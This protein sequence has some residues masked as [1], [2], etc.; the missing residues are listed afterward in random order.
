MIYKKC[1]RCQL[2]Y[3]TADRELCDICLREMRGEKD[4]FDDSLC[5]ICPFCEKYP[6]VDGEEMCRHCRKKRLKA[7]SCDN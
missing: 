2:N 3:V 1:S 7:H 5:D 6:L 4:D